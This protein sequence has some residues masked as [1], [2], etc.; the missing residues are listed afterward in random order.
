MRSEK[1][2]WIDIHEKQPEQ[3]QTVLVK[4]GW[5][6]YPCFENVRLAWYEEKQQLFYTDSPLIDEIHRGFISQE[7]VELWMPIPQLL[8]EWRQG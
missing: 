4:F 5:M 3:H 6:P 2:G 7:L 8:A 1:V